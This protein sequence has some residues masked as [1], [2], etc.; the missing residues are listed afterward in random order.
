M[1]AEAVIGLDVGAP[2]REPRQHRRSHAGSHH[3]QQGVV[4]RA[5]EHDSGSGAAARECLLHQRL[6][7]GEWP[8]HHGGAVELLQP[9]RT[10]G[11]G[12]VAGHQEVRVIEQLD[13][14]DVG[15]DPAV[16]EQQVEITDPRLLR[17]LLGHP[18]VAVGVLVSQPS[19]DD[20]Q[21]HVGHA[22]EGADVDPAVARLEPVDSVAQSFCLRQQIATVLEDHCAQRGDP[23]RPGPTRPI[24]HLAADGSLQ[25]GDLLAHRRLGIT[26]P[27]GRPAEGALVGHGDHRGEV[28]QLEVHESQRSGS[29]GSDD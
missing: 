15:L 23:Y 28:A 14:L 3:G 17:L 8:G 11:E 16:V 19:Y 10:V 20:R 24:E 12:A 9:D 29:I 6:V 5:T 25:R 18:D 2:D 27:S 1:D 7:A 13:V 22:L 26:E 21:D 4:D